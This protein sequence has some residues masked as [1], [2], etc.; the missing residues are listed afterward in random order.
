MGKKEGNIIYKRLVRS[1]LSSVIS[2]TLILLLVGVVCLFLVNARYISNY[3]KENISVSAFV[4]MDAD[5]AKVVELK[6]R[7]ET[8]DYSKEVEIITKEQGIKEMKELLGEG[9]MDIFDFDPIPLSLDI[10][11]NAD[12]VSNDS[13]L[14]VKSI[15]L[16]EP[17]IEEVVYQE[18]LMDVLNAN[19]EKIGIALGIFVLFLLFIS[20]VLIAGTVRLNV[21][22]KRF[23]IHTM[24][25]VGAKKSFIIRPF[26]IQAGFQGLISGFLAVIC[27]IG[28]IF[29]IKNKFYQMF[30]LFNVNSLGFVLIFVVFLGV[31]ICMLSTIVVVNRIISIS[32]DE[33]YY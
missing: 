32:K 8:A 31:I 4:V 28:V 6:K 14:V 30:L 2:I 12:Y 26:V 25:L 22:A 24:R 15:L 19:I 1:Y 7:I 9:F 13:M 5:E 3:F 27:L 23:T 21:Y 17:I 10:K 20:S 18:S 29:M 33:L 11:L 16:E